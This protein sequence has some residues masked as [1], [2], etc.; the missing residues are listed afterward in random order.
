MSKKNQIK[1]W[2]IIA[3]EGMMFV[4]IAVAGWCLLP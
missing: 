3:L 4:S 1:G 2:T